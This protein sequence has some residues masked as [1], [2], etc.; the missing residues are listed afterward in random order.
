MA[1]VEADLAASGTDV[2]SE[3]DAMLSDY[4]GQLAAS[5]LGRS[6]KNSLREQIATVEELRSVRLHW[7]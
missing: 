1:E 5:D 7:V 3:L 6:E 4:R 2:I